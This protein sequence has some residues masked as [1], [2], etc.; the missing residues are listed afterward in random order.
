MKGPEEK[1]ILFDLNFLKS[2]FLE[3]AAIVGGFVTLAEI[4]GWHLLLPV[5]VIA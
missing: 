5:Y 1:P 2:R 3:L 4:F